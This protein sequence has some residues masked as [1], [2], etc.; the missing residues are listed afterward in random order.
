[1][2][3]VHRNPISATYAYLNLPH[4]SNAK[5]KHGLLLCGTN[6][7]QLIYKTSL[8]NLS[9]HVMTCQKKVFDSKDQRLVA[10][11][12]TGTGNVDACKVRPSNII[13]DELQ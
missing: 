12:V 11:G 7:N 6:I 4:I 3:Q 10:G 2:M 13:L 1:S 9:Q 5:E 8:R